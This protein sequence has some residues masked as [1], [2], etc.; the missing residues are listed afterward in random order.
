MGT[1]LI[2]GQVRSVAGTPRQQ[3]LDCVPP[4]AGL[5]AQVLHLC[6]S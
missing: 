3:S 4:L 6:S 2:L 1:A 5:Y